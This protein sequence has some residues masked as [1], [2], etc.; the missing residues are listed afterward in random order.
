MT[1]IL[2]DRLSQCDKLFWKVALRACSRKQRAIEIRVICDI[3]FRL[4]S[5]PLQPTASVSIPHA[6]SLWELLAQNSPLRAGRKLLSICVR[7]TSVFLLR[8]SDNVCNHY[9]DASQS[10]LQTCERCLHREEDSE[11][12]LP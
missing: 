2:S 10:S 9:I 12:S 7:D 11:V 6:P 3:R 8:K 5:P 4:S 1:E